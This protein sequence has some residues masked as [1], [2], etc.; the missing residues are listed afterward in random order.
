MFEGDP[1]RVESVEIP[2]LIHGEAITLTAEALRDIA[3]RPVEQ[4]TVTQ[5]RM[6]EA[7]PSPRIGANADVI[8][9]VLGDPPGFLDVRQCCYVK[10]TRACE[11]PQICP[12]R[13]PCLT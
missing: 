13:L 3:C 11:D 8:A 12:R 7:G 9:D 1:N 4:Y 10:V 2:R 5:V 6:P